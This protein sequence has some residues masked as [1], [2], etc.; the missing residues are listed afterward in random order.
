MRRAPAADDLR[1]YRHGILMS[2]NHIC[3]SLRLVC[4]SDKSSLAASGADAQA[5]YAHG[6]VRY[7]GL[8]LAAL[9]DLA[10]FGIH[11]PGDLVDLLS[12]VRA[13]PSADPSPR[14]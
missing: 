12:G 2:Y 9:N 1:A 10:P 6:V 4:R 3:Y 7:L 14:G 5:L 8:G 11:S 13:A